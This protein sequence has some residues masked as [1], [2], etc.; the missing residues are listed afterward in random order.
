MVVLSG[1]LPVFLL[2]LNQALSA[3]Q[4]QHQRYA[5]TAHRTGGPFYADQRHEF[6][7]FNYNPSCLS[8][9]LLQVFLS[10]PRDLVATEI[11]GIRSIWFDD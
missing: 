11:L 7:Q 1:G 2:A 6:F 8:V 5:V 10:L 3:A 4:H 9:F